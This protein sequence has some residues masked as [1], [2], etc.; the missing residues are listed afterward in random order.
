MYSLAIYVYMVCASIAAI[1]NKKARLLVRGHRSAFQVLRDNIDHNAQYIWVH[2]ASLGEFEQ[3]RSLIEKIKATYP[4]YRILLTFFSPSG[5]EVRK[6]YKGADVIC[7]LPF[8]T[9]LNARKFLK[10]ARPSMAFF[11]KY[12]FWQNYL[13]ML[14]KK[15]VPT[16]SVSSIFRPNQIFFRWYGKHY[17]HV[18]QCFTHLFVQNETSRELLTKLGINN[19]TIVGDTRFDRVIDIAKA[20]KRTEICDAFIKCIKDGDHLLVAGSTWP[21]DEKFL[22]EYFNTHPNQKLILAPHVVSDKHLDEIDRQLT[23]PAVRYSS[24]SVENVH[25]SDCLIIDC[26]GMLSSIYAYGNMAYVGGGFGAGIHNVPEAAVHGL[27]V[28]IGPKNKNFKEAQELLE[29]G[30]CF[31]IH[32]G[33]E[34][35]SIIENLSSNTTFCQNAGKIC[36]KYIKENAGAT[37][38]IFNAIDF[39]NIPQYGETSQR[40]VYSEMK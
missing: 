6:N 22:L 39:C 32:S 5:Y 13:T 35:N 16:F 31:E 38:C 4:Q 36:Q 34:Y 19:V 30:G 3:G 10:L 33:E 17:A 14:H 15:G 11:I 29:K 25:K 12:E 21:Q 28:I 8:D 2:V 37:D 26:Y 1:F 7:Y 20:A 27:P 23:R 24:A 9:A 40:P 18:L